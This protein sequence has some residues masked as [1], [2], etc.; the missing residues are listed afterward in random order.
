MLKTTLMLSA[1]AMLM[2]SV[3]AMSQAQDAEAATSPPS[4]SAPVTEPY[5]AQDQHGAHEAQPQEAAPVAQHDPSAAEQQAAMPEAADQAEQKGDEGEQL[6]QSPAPP[7]QQE[8]TPEIQ[9]GPDADAPD[10][11]KADPPADEQPNA[12][13][14]PDQAEPAAQPD[15]PAPAQR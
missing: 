9:G 13:E 14:T 6:A 2:L 12:A 7:I 11:L 1:A 8:S 3:P 5:V 4:A 15:E 10:E